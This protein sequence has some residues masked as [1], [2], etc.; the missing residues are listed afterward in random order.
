MRD[1]CGRTHRLPVPAGDRA[2]G[3]PVGLPAV[4]PTA[5]LVVVAAVAVVLVNPL[6][7]AA[8]VPPSGAPVARPVAAASASPPELLLPTPPVP[9]VEP[10]AP[11]EGLTGGEGAPQ[12]KDLPDPGT[13]EPDPPG[14]GVTALLAAAGGLAL[15]VAAFVLGRRTA[16]PRLERPEGDGSPSAGPAPEGSAPAVPVEQTLV[17][18][19]ISVHDLA[20]E[21]AVQ[22]SVEQTLRS[23]GVHRVVS[24]SGDLL[25]VDVHEV[26]GSRS[27]PVPDVDGRIDQV[28]RPGWRQR[29]ALLRPAQVRVFR[30]GR[31]E[32][33]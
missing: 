10:S 19:L 8:G 12:P 6:A 33:Q 15:T 21:E 4:V 28:V 25:D 26:V 22:A 7:A 2:G 20:G 16:R 9:P 1:S 14:S 24:A 13:P 17:S 31:P 27:S 29:D 23:V 11:G 32:E 5:V 3:P 18:G 30:A